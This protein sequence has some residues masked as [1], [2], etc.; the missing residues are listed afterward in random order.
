MS[1]VEDTADAVTVVQAL[2]VRPY[3]FSSSREQAAAIV[4]ALTSSAHDQ[5]TGAYRR[6]LMV[7]ADRQAMPAIDVIAVRAEVERVQEAAEAR[8]RWWAGTD[9]M[10]YQH[11]AAAVLADCL[12]ALN[13]LKSA[14]QSV[15]RIRAWA[16]RHGT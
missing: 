13:A 9:R 11:D 14:E 8:N 6:P 5:D 1:S 16:E 12:D 7:P 10:A 15:V 3:M 4:D 2:L